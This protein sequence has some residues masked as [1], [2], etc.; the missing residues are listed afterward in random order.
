MSGISASK[1]KRLAAKAAKAEAKGIKSAKSSAKSTPIPSNNTSV[2]DLSLDKM[3]IK[4]DRTATGVYTSQ[5]RS[6]DIKIESY[7]L[8]YHGRVLI[9]NATIE[10][11]FGRRYGLIGANG[12]GKSTFLASLAERDIEIPDHIDTYLLNQEAE[13]SD[14]NAVDAVIDHAQKEVARLEKQVEEILSQEDGADNPLLDDIYERI[15]GMD[16]ATFEARACSLLSGLGFTS[17]QMLKMTKDMSGGWRMRVALA[18]ALFVRP[19][20]LLLDEP[21][22]HLDLEACVW[23]EE[24]LKTY[25]RILVIVSHSQ[26]F[27][28]GVCTNMMHLN[29]KRKLIYYG[30]NYDMFVKIKEENEINQAKAYEKQQEEIAHIKKFIASAGTYANLVRQAKSKQK[31]ID[32]MEAAGLVEK[33]EKPHAFKFSFTDV[34]KLP[35]PVLAFQEVTFSYSGDIDKALY[36]DIELGVDMDSRVA[37]VGPNGAGKSTLLKLMSG[38]LVPT[39]GRVQRH[40]ALKLGKYSQHSADQLDMDLSPIDYM[41]RKFPQ[42]STETDFWRRQIGRYGLTGAHQTSPIE[43]L[44]DGLKSR[45]VFAELAVMRPHIIL[46]DEPTNHLDMESIDSLAEAINEFSGGVVLVSHDFRLISQ[47]AKQIWR[48]ENGHVMP[49]E[50]SIA[51]YKESLRKNVKL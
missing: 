17:Q 32:K 41:K 25:N 39:S 11:N 50:G 23:L 38:E 6:R 21:T 4:V 40:T 9:D 42:E 48:C 43:H 15:E 14:M 29:H 24:Y 12:S 7:S 20:L 19:T 44:S 46:L 2:E 30:G 36:K 3:K 47:V 34:A 5:E 35:P 1:A 13:P 45:L 37:L 27:L 49:F 22:N 28:N 33:V 8:N 18:R 16:P 51:E 10:L 31:I 26:D